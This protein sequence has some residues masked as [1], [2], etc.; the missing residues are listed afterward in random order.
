MKKE[1]RKSELARVRAP[2]GYH[3]EVVKPDYDGAYTFVRLYKKG[4]QYYIG[5]ISLEPYGTKTYATHSRLEDAYHGKGLGAIM[6]AKAI[7][8]C[9]DNGYKVR[10]SGSPSEYAQRVWGGSSLRRY[11]SIRQTTNGSY[12]KTW[13]VLKQKKKAAAKRAAKKAK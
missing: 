6:Y 2:K 10:S 9:L 8:W 7:Q 11:F 13:A 4:V 12:Y 1:I 5:Q 3:F